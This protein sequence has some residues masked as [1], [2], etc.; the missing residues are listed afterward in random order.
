[1]NSDIPLD[2]GR[3]SSWR[4]LSAWARRV[5]L[6]RKAAV[7]LLLAA[8]MSGIVTYVTITNTPD[9]GLESNTVL[10]LIILN[11]VLLLIFGAVVAQRLVE[12]WTQRRRGLAGSRLHTRLVVMFSAI[13]VT[14]TIIVAVFSYLFLSIGLQ[15]WFS[16][17]VQT[18]LLE[19]RAVAQAYLEEHHR[20]I[21]SD[22]IGMA[23]DID[24]NALAVISGPGALNDLIE[25]EVRVRSLSEAAVYEVN[26]TFSGAYLL[27]VL[28]RSALA[29]TLDFERPPDEALQKAKDDGVAI[30][31]NEDRV[32]AL[33]RLK[34]FPNM[35]LYV[36]RPVEPRVLQH[37]QANDE[38]VEQ[39]ERRE[40]QRS[41]FQN[42][43]MLIFGAFAMLLLL[44]A[45][46]FGLN[47]ATQISR[48]I[49]GLVVAAERVR[50]GDLSARVFEV[51]ENDEFGSLSRAFNR[52]TG[53]L[54]S[55]QCELVEANRQLDLRRRFTEAVL[56]GVSA[57]VIGLDEQGL[58][59]L[60]NRSAS[61]L[62]GIDFDQCLG[63]PLAR[64]VPE[65]AP[66]IE[67]AFA[68]P[69]RQV[70]AQ[71][72][73]LMRG[74]ATVLLVR[75]ANERGPG[76]TPGFVVTFDDI[77]ELL[78]AQRKAA[79]AD[80]ARRI[81]HEMKNPLTPIQLSAE[82][83]KR[84]YLSQITTDA[85]TF[86]ICTDTIIRQVGDIGRM[87]DEFSS[88][89]RM[90]APTMKREVLQDITRQAVF[91]QRTAHADI[92]FTVDIPTEPIEVSCDSR[93]ISQALINLLQNAI[94]SIQARQVAQASGGTPVPGRIQVRL[95]S[96]SGR[97]VLMVEDNGKGLP[98]EG[99]ENLTEPY[100]TTRAK[101]T[102]L[103]LAIVK[104]IMED[105]AGEL[106]LQDGLDGGA[107]VSLAFAAEAAHPVKR[108]I[109]LMKDDTQPAASVADPHKE[110]EVAVH[111]A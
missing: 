47:I 23:T 11:L 84:K 10:A 4:R 57:G 2:N 89:A 48:R 1:M 15:S 110:T 9:I 49:S 86:K 20:N 52:M 58:I 79:W 40:G 102:G 69:E 73:L 26:Q 25:D 13:A 66:L 44:A 62:L 95:R 42:G 96:G 30:V 28:G 24:R 101:G 97:A 109:T 108:R 50:G 7:V 99:R 93:Q 85:E 87:V 106:V 19:S 27:R 12:I 88:F 81:A 74:T 41:A 82:R 32:W 71:I 100:V 8:V 72:R 111:G 76:E 83:L 38:A 16:E 3:G 34:Q 31:T 43:F 37:I 29:F 103:G 90:P 45:V 56:S 35:M 75:I 14:P 98:K 55:Q 67:A 51:D 33:V 91:L 105:H 94:D 92:D 39:Y 53:Q 80:V 78:G 21:E 18:A 61:T 77:T 70:E 104:K 63:Q 22:A 68:L 65:M 5:R 36:G 17:T 107:Q 46:W 54:E 6:E 64:I 59:H 60:P